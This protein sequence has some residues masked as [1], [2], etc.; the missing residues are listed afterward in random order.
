MANYGRPA[1]RNEAQD[2]FL[3]MYPVKGVATPGVTVIV[4]ADGDLEFAPAG[5]SLE[6]LV[7]DGSAEF[8]FDDAT[9]DVVYDG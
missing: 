7:D 1:D 2:G 9:S 4:N 8:L 3:R 5:A 6:G